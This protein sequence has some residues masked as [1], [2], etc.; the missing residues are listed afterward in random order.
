MLQFITIFLIFLYFKIARV[1]KKEEKLDTKFL[2]QHIVVAIGAF[3]FYG[4][5]FSNGHYVSA[6]IE[7]FLSFILAAMAITAVQVGIF[8]DGKPFIG[9]SKIY[10]YSFLL[11]ALIV[12]LV[13]ITIL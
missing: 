13:A 1:H 4:Y 7:S 6:V 9:L 10:K 3:V 11:V 12:L 2:I 8:V 5:V